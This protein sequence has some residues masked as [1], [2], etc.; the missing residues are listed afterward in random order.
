[1]RCGAFC[2]AATDA[3]AGSTSRATTFLADQIMVFGHNTNLTVAGTLYHVQTEDRGAGHARIDT[4]VYC[5]G[6]VLHRRVGKYEDLL[7]LD[8]QREQALRK[9]VDDQHRTV[10]EEMRSG[11]L[12]LGP[13][14]GN[15]PAASAAVKTSSSAA[16]AALA[17]ELLNAK[18]WLSGK[19]ATLRIA[20]RDRNGGTP[21]AGAHVAARIEGAAT[22]SEF[23]AQTDHEGQARMEFDMPAFSSN[24]EPALMIEAGKDAAKAR[25]RF[26]L[27]ARP[28]VS[29]T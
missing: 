29:S 25:L 9:R 1:M 19:R 26:Q 5:C 3:L 13:G 28:R 8:A 18:S 22:T 11:A 14:A 16:S 2:T 24:V 23:T 17:V 10:V 4:M 27:R 7:P 6:R 21:V 15:A 20:V 12:P